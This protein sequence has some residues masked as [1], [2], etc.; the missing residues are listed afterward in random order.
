MKK[1]ILLPVIFFCLGQL[2]GQVIYLSST[3]NR[4]YRLNIVTCNYTQIVQLSRGITDISFHPDGTLYGIDS[5]GNLFKIDTLSGATTNVYQFN[6]AGQRFN[7]LTTSATG[8][9][10]STGDTGALFSYDNSTGTGTFLGFIGFRATGDLT[11]YKGKLYAAAENDRIILVDLNNPANSS[12]AID[13]NIFGEIFGIVSYSASCDSINCYAI[14]SGNSDIYEINFASKSL[15]LKCQLNIRVG[16]GAST[17]EFFGSA[18]IIYNDVSSTNPTCSNSDGSLTINVTGGIAPLKYSLDGVNYQPSNTFSNLPGGSYQFIVSDANGCTIIEEVTLLS[19]PGPVIENVAMVPS[20]CGSSNGEIDVSVNGGNGMIGY[21]IDALSYQSSPVFSNLSSGHYLITVRDTAGCIAI[22]SIDLTALSLDTIESISASLI[23]CDE[24][25]GSLIIEVQNGNGVQYSIDGINFQSKNHFDQL[26]PATYLVTIRDINGCKDTMTAMI[27]PPVAV[28]I[29]QVATV[30]PLCDYDKGSIII[31]ASGGTGQITYSLDD[32]NFQTSNL[33]DQLTPLTYQIIIRD[34]NGCRD[35]TDALINPGVAMNIED[36]VTDSSHCTTSDGSIIVTP[37]GGTGQIEYSID[38]INFQPLNH[39]DFLA[40]SNY[41]IT[42][43]DQN[44]CIDTANTTISSINA[45]VIGNIESIPTRCDIADGSLEVTPVGEIGQVQY[46][47]DGTNFQSSNKFSNLGSGH[48]IIDIID[49]AGCKAMAP[50]DIAEPLP[51]IIS[52]IITQ[53]SACEEITGSMVIHF[54]GGTGQITFSID[55]SSFQ[56]ENSF[57]QLTGG[58][59]QLI[60]ADENGCQIDTTIRIPRLRCKI[61]IP[62]SFSPNLDGINDFFQLST[63]DEF[64][65]TVTKYMIFDRWG[66]MVYNAEYFPIGSTEFWWDGTY[67]KMT[68]SSGVFAYYIEVKYEDGESDIF[69]GDVT[70]VK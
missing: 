11:F 64:N 28:L 8:I 22:D 59:H 18:P 34:D 57:Q 23:S 36:M 12:I 7:S 33:F 69:K 24:N 16:G 4:I 39:F 13:E 41:Q 66:N 52:G 20:T 42:I 48:Y 31:T 44:G 49:D 17:Y 46:S 5:G 6:G 47:I 40:P 19:S 3:N 51:I 15:Q 27:S 63:S 43:K 65:I 54:S 60:V 2:F 53:P 25:L 70:L 45:L 58:L 10:Y 56:T 32:I 21:S 29:D 55:G 38:G 9:S 30:D 67:K 61:Y 50:A 62:N 26:G 35:T 37:L 1:I 68:M 14:S